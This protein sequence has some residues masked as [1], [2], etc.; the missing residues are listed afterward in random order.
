MNA[1]LVVSILLKQSK[2]GMLQP[3]NNTDKVEP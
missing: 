2:V 1:S 3:D